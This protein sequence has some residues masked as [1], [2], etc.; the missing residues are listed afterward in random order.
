MPWFLHERLIRKDGTIHDNGYWQ[1]GC[2]E[3]KPEHGEEYRVYNVFGGYHYWTCGK[4]CEDKQNEIVYAND[5]D[6]LD[7]SALIDNDSRIGWLA[8][9]GRF[10]GCGYMQHGNIADLVLRKS[11]IELENEGWVKMYKTQLF[12]SSPPEYYIRRGG[13]LTNEQVKVLAEKGYEICP[14]DMEKNWNDDY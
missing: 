8:P 9:D 14:W 11:E 5:W 3:E 6:E 7:H 1:I 2:D 10:Y 12:P 13:C 4:D